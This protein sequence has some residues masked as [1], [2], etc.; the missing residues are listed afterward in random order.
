MNEAFD[1][2]NKTD[3]PFYL[4]GCELKYQLNKDT[5]KDEGYFKS[6]CMSGDL[7]YQYP[8]D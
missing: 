1:C 4:M 8:E 7:I 2:F 6:K 5:V 3:F